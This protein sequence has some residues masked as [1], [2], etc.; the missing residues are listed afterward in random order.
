M[1]QSKSA[2]HAKDYF[3]SSLAQSDYYISDQELEGFW[4]GRLAA[5][6][7]LSGATTKDDFFALCENV[8]PKTGDNLTPRKTENRTTGYDINFH[9]P[10]S[11]SLLHVFSKDDQIL[12]AFRDSVS[13]TMKLIEADAK[14]RV[15]VGGKHEDR[16]TDEL[17]WAQFVHQTA[18]PVKDILPDPH[19]HSHCFVFNATWDETEQRIKAGQFR[20]ILRDASFYQAHFHKSLSD[21]LE[22]LGYD[23]YKTGRSFEV[24]GVPREA[25]N[26]FSKRTDEIGRIAKERGITDQNKLGELGARTRSKK[27]KGHTM[28]EL[29]EEWREQLEAVDPSLSKHLERRPGRFAIKQQKPTRSPLHC[30]DHAILHSFERSSVMDERRLLAEAIRHSIG[31]TGTT[32]SSIREAFANDERIIR[33]HDSGRD[34]CTTKEVLAEEKRMVS[35][36]RA[37]QDMLNPLYDVSPELALDGQQGAAIKHVL[38]TPH[39]VSIIRGAAGSGKTTL[40]KE[41]FEKIEATGKKM[42]VVAPTAQ[43][44]RGVLREDEGFEGAETVARLLGSEDMQ[45]SL[46]GQVLWVDEAGLLGTRD[47]TKLLEIVT[48]QD[49]RLILGGDTRQHASVVRGDALR[50]LNTVAGIK[51]AEVNK[52]RRQQ[53]EQY[54]SAVEDLSKGDVGKAFEKLDGMECIKT[55]DPMKPHEQI[56]NDY[57]A[58]VKAG[59]S[60]LVVSPTHMQGEE[61]TAKI[62]ERLRESGMLGKKEITVGQLHNLKMTEAEKADPRNLSAGQVVQ[63]NQNVA[64]GYQRGSLWQ[65][66]RSDEGKI[67][68]RN[69][70]GKVKDLP[71]DRSKDY[72]I[73]AVRDLALSKGDKVMITQNGFDENHKR[74]DNGMILEVTSVAKDGCVTMKNPK[75]NLN[76]TISKDFGHVAHAHCITSYAS[77]GKTVD[78]VFI[79]QPAATFPA[80][81]AKQ[82]YV[83][84]SRG[85]EGVTIYTDDKDELLR[86][87]ME[88]GERKS[89]IELVDKHELSRQRSIDQRRQQKTPTEP[90]NKNNINK[91]HDGL[92][93]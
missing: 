38:T 20:D 89:A 56:V 50:I 13:D 63:F 9:C 26:L 90:F 41:A 24:V 12:D 17:I 34:L 55:I 36:A 60:A 84:V 92:D 71:T 22:Y 42:T 30:V 25:T 67:Q 66:E 14:T 62:R 6:L 40:M 48:K 52:I 77:Q 49:A 54:R 32:A 91:N 59:K 85:K 3:T 4:E 73:Y 88:L 8:N 80:T 44:S 43:A 46:K 27:Q 21:R 33:V 23:T 69:A 5:R 57:V 93:R 1:V 2:S 18:R 15:R 75:S 65:V 45:N 61:V 37:G 7:G 82:F 39:R 74:L 19:L 11:V 78:H 16:N 87:A 10:K 29:K 83:C 68:I 31:A 86:H 76:Y 28:D 79:H 53:N 81:D 58:A 72:D 64:G 35:L 70:E 51:S 47:M